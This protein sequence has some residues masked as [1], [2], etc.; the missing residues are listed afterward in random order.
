MNWG[1]KRYLTSLFISCYTLILLTVPASQSK[2]LAPSCDPSIICPTLY[3]PVCGIDGQTYGNTCEAVK[4]CVDIAYPGV[5]NQ[6]PQICRDIDRDGFSPTGGNCGPVDCND[7]N[8]NINPGF[9][10]P[11]Y[12]V[13]AP[14]CGE[15]GFT[16]ASACEAEQSCIKIAYEGECLAQPPCIDNDMDGYSPD[17][18][19]CGP[20]DCN[21]LNADINP[22]MYCFDLYAPVCGVDGN[23]YSNSCEAKQGCMEIA[24]EGEC[25]QPPTCTDE[26]LDGFAVEGGLCGAT[27]CNDVDPEIHP[28]AVEIIG[29][30]FDENC[31]GL[32]DDRYFIGTGND[33]LTDGYCSEHGSYITT[34]QCTPRFMGQEFIAVDNN[35]AAVE[36]FM[37]NLY[38]V[39]AEL[40]IN[41]R[42]SSMDGPI[43]GTSTYVSDTLSSTQSWQGW[44]L[45]DFAAPVMLIPG[46]L[47]IIELIHDT[48]PSTAWYW[49]TNANC[50]QQVSGAVICNYAR[51]E[52]SFYFRTYSTEVIDQDMDGVSPPDDCDDSNNA[53]NPDAPEIPYNGVDENCNGMNDDIDFDLDGYPF[54]QDCNDNDPTVNP[55]IICF[56]LYTP[57]CGI[58]GKTYGNVCEADQACVEI[59]HQGECVI[60]PVCTD[61]DSDGF[62]V[63]GAECGPIDCNDNEAGIN[64]NAGEII[65]N[66]VDENCNGMSDDNDMDRDGFGIPYDCNDND[67]TI[68][69]GMICTTVYNPVCG[70]DG[71]TYNNACEAKQSC[72][73]ID[74]DGGCII[75]P[76][77]TDNDQDGFAVEGG[78][79]GAVDCDDDNAAINPFAEEIYN[80]NSDENCNGM[81][82]DFAVI[83]LITKAAYSRSK[84]RLTVYAESEL[85]RDDLLVLEGYGDME[86][87]RRRDRWTI[88]VKK[89]AAELLPA[90]VTVSGIYGSSKAAVEIR[91]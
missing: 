3:D 37:K 31:N 80:N 73:E 66:G 87:N 74:P 30:N 13:Y 44:A 62:A 38:G 26:D 77:C 21:D 17:G 51:P 65:Y 8:P 15:D 47:Y 56:A 86:W 83:P 29:N 81:D 49:L 28:A 33:P 58:D 14:V 52:E 89:L 25:Y 24:Y 34:G 70:V 2:A 61:A 5:C 23:T 60:L 11:L 9:V 22:G 48:A 79:C 57:V 91:R 50:D 46:N 71:N 67:P 64:P 12:F 4:F 53:V 59:A 40:N 7:Y 32:T 16:Y 63:D 78:D 19:T 36:I 39:A 54:T 90:T 55:D 75:P 85:G 45:F 88:T 42:E 1:N 69:P 6:P 35:L 41:I 20:I 43:I 10:C 84:K 72:V 82:D 18:G 68:N 27:D 76:T